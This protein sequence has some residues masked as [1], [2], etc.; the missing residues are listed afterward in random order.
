MFDSIARLLKDR[1]GNVLFIATMSLPV[2]IGAGGLATDT[3]QWTLWQKEMQRQ[4]DSAA[5]AGAYAKAQGANVTTNATTDLNRYSLVTLSAAPTIENAPTTG[6][7]AG[8]ANAVRVALQTSQKLPF[9]SLF[10]ATAPT[11]KAEATAAVVNNGNYCILAFENTTATGITMQGNATVNMG[12][13]MATNSTAA[14]AVTAGGS[15]S[16]YATPIS[17]V[18]GLQSSSNYASGTVLLPHSITQ[19]DPYANLPTPVVPSGGC[20]HLTV[21]SGQTKHVNN[22]TS[23]ACYQ[24]MDLR[25]TVNFDQGV[26]YIDGDMVNIGSQAVI[27]GT[28]VTFILTSNN[29]TSNPSSI[30]TWR[31]NGGAA[32]NL[33]ASTSGTYAGVLIYQ[34]RRALDSGNNTI[35]GN[36]TSGFQGAIY[37]PSQ[38]VDF[39][40]TSGMN[41]Q[42]IQI[43][44]RRVTFIG[45]TS[46]ANNC[47]SGSGAS[48]FTGTRVMLV[49]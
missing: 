2:V 46:I 47:P 16:I 42:C 26:Y 1:A 12:C 29:A 15:S 27:T 48:S 22:P 8:N 36:A 7:Y 19:Q 13:G 37:I 30:A 14:N 5:L 21:G 31:T 11:I 24:G 23:V 41:T 34:D 38:E 25:G 35:N 9:S 3:I 4:A 17:A 20:P 39:S 28:N 44:S 49:G 10:L 32:V 45:N 6:S 40:G 33:T 18:G 43:A